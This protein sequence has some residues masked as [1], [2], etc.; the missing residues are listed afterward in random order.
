MKKFFYGLILATA[1]LGG[2]A[3]AESHM[4][5]EGL[6]KAAKARQAT[7]QL[8]AFNLGVLG[9]MAK[10]TTDYDA[11]AASAAAGNLVKLSTQ[12]QT[13]YW[14]PGTAQGEIEGSRALPAIWDDMAGVSE[15]AQALVDAAM[16]LEEAAGTD[17]DALRA[18]MGGLGGA[19]GGCHKAYR[20]SQ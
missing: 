7:M 18:A 20:A 11:E 3:M 6:M 10:G 8:Y 17:L 14:L 16:T 19:C 4:S 9:N 15:A 2:T 12:D 1:G 5:N 13:A